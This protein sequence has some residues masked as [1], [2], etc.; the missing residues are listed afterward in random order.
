MAGAAYRSLVM[1]VLILQEFAVLV[2]TA[3][4]ACCLALPSLAAD[5]Y[6]VEELGRLWAGPVS[7]TV[8]RPARF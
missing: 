1:R 3:A 4:L 2:A 5:A 7:A 6:K 8:A